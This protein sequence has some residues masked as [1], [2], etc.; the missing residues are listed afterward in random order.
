MFDLDMGK[1]AAFVWPA[2]TISAVVLAALAARALA[3]SRR[4]NA[5]LKRLEANGPDRAQAARSA[6]AQTK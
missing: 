2:W 3:A 6:V 4:W 5:E 1:Y